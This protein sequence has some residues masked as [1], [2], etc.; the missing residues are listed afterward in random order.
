[1]IPFYVL[2]A[3]SLLFRGLGAAG[4]SLFLDWQNCIR[5]ALALMFLLT[6]S[7]HWGKRRPDLIRMV[8]PGVPR[9][10]LM[11]TLTGWAEIL[12]AAGLLWKRT[13]PLSAIAL[14]AMLLALFPANVF[15]ARHGLTIGGR[16]VPKLIPRA[17]LQIVFLTATYFAGFGF[18]LAR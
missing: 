2:V 9:P 18:N 5:F 8:P 11:V 6:A 12:G 1:M 13:A 3:G 4:L 14:M 7:A 17:I 16:R 15:A 10:A